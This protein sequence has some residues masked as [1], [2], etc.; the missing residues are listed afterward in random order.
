MRRITNILALALLALT[1]S[2]C[3][4]VGDLFE[5]AFWLVA[6]GFILVLAVIWWLF[7]KIRGVGRREPPPPG[8]PPA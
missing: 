2:G 5:I 1:A 3:E 7:N 6:I 8:P 4:L